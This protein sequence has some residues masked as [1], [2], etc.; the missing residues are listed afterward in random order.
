MQMPLAIGEQPA[1]Y[2]LNRDAVSHSRE[3]VE[4]RHACPLVVADVAGRHERHPCPPPHRRTPSEPLLVV[5]L[6]GDL[7]DAHEPVA[8]HLAPLHDRIDRIAHRMTASVQKRRQRHACQ[9]PLRMTCD[10]GA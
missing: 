3:R 1:T 5:S 7:G 10:V 8:K 2:R 6:E 9:E 4:E